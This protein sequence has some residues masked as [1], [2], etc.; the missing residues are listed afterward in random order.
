METVKNPGISVLMKL[1]LT[2]TPQELNQ[3]SSFGYVNELNTFSKNSSFSYNIPLDHLFGFAADYRKLII[4]SRLE[5]E[6]LRSRNDDNCV[7]ASANGPTELDI[8][9]T[10]V[11][12]KVPQY[13][14]AENEKLKFLKIL[15]SNKS[16]PIPFRSF[17]LIENP[18]LQEATSFAWNIKTS[19]ERP[20]YVVLTFQKNKKDVL[21]ENASRFDHCDAKNVKLFINDTQW[22]YSNQNFHFETNKYN[23]AYTA[24]T[25]FLATYAN[26][27]G[28]SSILFAE[29]KTR[30]PYFVFDAR[31]MI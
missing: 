4:Y 2:S 19:L 21:T 17:E 5:L 6:L 23:D 22:P 16:I 27:K 1:L 12:W 14:V 3:A 31:I 29:F 24:F 30:C 8:Q 9:I 10:K 13:I 26:K 7:V 18:A 15:E 11:A 25:K 20:L 28:Q